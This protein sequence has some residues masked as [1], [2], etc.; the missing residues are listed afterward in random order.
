MDD[1]SN[2]SSS[3]GGNNNDG[4]DNKND[5]HEEE[6]ASF[7]EPN[8]AHIPPLLALAPIQIPDN[9]PKIPLVAIS[10]N[11]LFPN[12]IKMLEVWVLI[13]LK[14]S[15]R[16]QFLIVCWCFICKISNKNLIDVIRRRAHLNMPY[17][18]VFMRKD[19]K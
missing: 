2:S 7:S 11:P 8:Q 15:I 18:G 3:D 5:P 13:E 19:D 14:F 16:F 17:I 12:F 6:V 9:F 1:N 10:R 4:N